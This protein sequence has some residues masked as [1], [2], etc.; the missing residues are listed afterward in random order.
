LADQ[1]RT[2]FSRSHRNRPRP[3]I[4]KRLEE[5]FVAKDTHLADHNRSPKPL[6]GTA[7]I[8]VILD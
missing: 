2:S 4:V 6:L 8:W 1:G 3:G 5:L 7:I